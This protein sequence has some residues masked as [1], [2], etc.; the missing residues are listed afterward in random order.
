M[1]SART[2]VVLQ[3]GNML[4]ITSGNR[5]AVWQAPAI[6]PHP[7]CKFGRPQKPALRLT[8]EAVAEIPEL[9]RA[10]LPRLA[11]SLVWAAWHKAGELCKPKQHCDT[12]RAPSQ[13]FD[14]LL[15]WKFPFMELLIHLLSLPSRWFSN[16]LSPSHCP[17]VFFS[18][19]ILAWCMVTN[20]SRFPPGQ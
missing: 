6:Q 14:Y 16:L 11:A 8:W 10:M 19:K 15:F 12:S 3:S 9:Q 2:V 17:S 13:N 18:P 5:Y 1:S 7:S 20:A 4:Q